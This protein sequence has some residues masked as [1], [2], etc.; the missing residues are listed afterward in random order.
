VEE[1]MGGCVHRGKVLVY[2][3]GAELIEIAEGLT[4][5][6]GVRGYRFFGEIRDMVAFG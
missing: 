2:N 3:P 6:R 4:P 1:M 5:A